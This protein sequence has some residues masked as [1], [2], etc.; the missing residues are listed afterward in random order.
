M[1]Q[2][3]KCMSRLESLA[4]SCL[5]WM[6]RLYILQQPGAVTRTSLPGHLT[7]WSASIKS[8]LRAG[9]SITQTGEETGDTKSSVPQPLK[10]CW[11]WWAARAV[12]THQRILDRPAAT[13]QRL[14]STL[15]SQARHCSQTGSV[16]PAITQKCP[17]QSWTPAYQLLHEV[18]M[19]EG[20][21]STARLRMGATSCDGQKRAGFLMVLLLRGRCLP[22]QVQASLPGAR[23][24]LEDMQPGAGSAM[25][26][27]LHLEVAMVHQYYRQA[28]AAQSQLDQAAAVLGVSLSVTG[29]RLALH[30]ACL[31]ASAQDLAAPFTLAVAAAQKHVDIMQP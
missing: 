30:A 20:R 12:M 10:A 3:S 29:K 21:A 25:Q 26:A 7:P 18:L 28:A 16:Q 23:S 27:A 22:V 2:P 24:Q 4:V 8:S 6:H 11:P 17:S 5:L 13:L 1:S 15:Y 19:L 14:T 9:L 31:P